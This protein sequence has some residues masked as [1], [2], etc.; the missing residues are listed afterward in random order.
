MRQT[1]LN[2]QWIPVVVSLLLPAAAW[3]SAG[4]TFYGSTVAGSTFHRPRDLDELSAVGTAVRFSFQQFVVNANASCFIYNVQE[5][6]EYNGHISLYQGHFST[7]DPLNNLIAVNDNAVGG[8]GGQSVIP[9]IDL[10]TGTYY[11]L[12]TSGFD[13]GDFGTFTTHIACSNPAT[14]V[15]AGNGPF[16][17]LDGTVGELR[18]GSFQVRVEWRDFLGL[19]GVGTLVPL[20]SSDS[21]MFWF[22]DPANWELLVKIVNGCGHNQRYWVYYAATT[23]V[24]FTLQVD[25]TFDGSPPRS[26]FNPLGTTLMTS[27]TDIDAFGCPIL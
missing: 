2:R 6:G 16:P 27:V 12:V 1:T 3:G 7:L 14:R 25:A 22:F 8:L 24:E 11:T 19:T 17:V 15:I 21:A 9:D 13:N 18:G 26:Y 10:L 20:G 23:N 4:M 5:G